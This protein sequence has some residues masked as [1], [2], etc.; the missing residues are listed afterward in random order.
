[1]IGSGAMI[2]ASMSSVVAAIASARF[3]CGSWFGNSIVSVVKVVSIIPARVS[4][5]FLVWCFGEVFGGQALCFFSSVEEFFP[6]FV[7]VVAWPL[8]LF[9]WLSV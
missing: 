7:W 4:V 2:S 9:E 1:M 3:L 5:A 6:F 8:L